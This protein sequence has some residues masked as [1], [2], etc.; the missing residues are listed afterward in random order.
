MPRITI[1]LDVPTDDLA[2]RLADMSVNFSPKKSSNDGKASSAGSATSATS[3]RSKA[4][5]SPFVDT[6][7]PDD[8]T[9]KPKKEE[10]EEPWE[11]E[12]WAILKGVGPGVY[13]VGSDEFT[14][15]RGVSRFTKYKK[16]PTYRAA[17]KAYDEA[18]RRGETC[19]YS[20]AWDAKTKNGMPANP[21]MPKSTA[22]GKSS[23]RKKSSSSKGAGQGGRGRPPWAHG[24]KRVFLER[25]LPEYIKIA[26][27]K[28][29]VS[30]LYAKITRM[31]LIKYT[32]DL[33]I[34][35]DS[36]EPLEDPDE[37]QL[38]EVSEYVDIDEAEQVRRDDFKREVHRRISAWY[39]VH[40]RRLPAATTGADDTFTSLLEEI[41]QPPRRGQVIHMYSKHH[42]AT[43][44]ASR[45][46]RLQKKYAATGDDKDD[47]GDNNDD[48]DDGEEGVGEGVEENSSDAGGADANGG[49]KP[50][51]RSKDVHLRMRAIRES[52]ATETEEVKREM[53]AL[54]DE[55]YDTAMEDYRS[56]FLQMPLT[57][58]EREWTSGHAYMFLQPIVDMVSTR[59]NCATSLFIAG[60]VPS[61]DGHVEVHSVHA[62]KKQGLIDELWPQHD[63][64]AYE[65]VSESMA[66]FARV[67]F[68]TEILRMAQK[69]SNHGGGAAPT[70]SSVS[71]DSAL[72]SD[73]P[74]GSTSFNAQQASVATRPSSLSTPQQSESTSG[75]A[76]PA[77]AASPDTALNLTA[78]AST[79]S[80]SD[81]AAEHG[82]S[83]PRTDSSACSG[84]APPTS[85]DSSLPVS[86][87]ATESSP[88]APSSSIPPYPSPLASHGNRTASDKA[89][90]T[91]SLGPDAQRVLDGT[92]RG[93]PDTTS[94]TAAG[95]VLPSNLPPESS[96]S[97]R[98]QAEKR[99]PTATP[100]D[101]IAR[102]VDGGSSMPPPLDLTASNVANAP[103]APRTT[104]L[105]IATVG[106]AATN[107]TTSSM[108]STTAADIHGAP[109][110]ATVTSTTAPLSCV[111]QPADAVA[112]SQSQADRGWPEL[113]DR[114]VMKFRSAALG[115]DWE[116][117]VTRFSMFEEALSF[118][119]GPGESLSL[120]TKHRPEEVRLWQK[121][122]RP[123]HNGKIINLDT[124]MTR[125]EDWWNALQPAERFNSEGE[126]MAPSASM[127][128]SALCIAGPNGLLSVLAALL[129]WGL[130]VKDDVE[131]Y[132]HQRWLN[133][134]VD[135]STV[136]FVS[137]AGNVA[138]ATSM[139]QAVSGSSKGRK[140]RTEAPAPEGKSKKRS[141]YVLFFRRAV[142][143]F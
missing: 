135:V 64:A 11:G 111:P 112:S 74:T 20:K 23:R 122:R 82:R 88:P 95:T 67:A 89:P 98:T 59:F 110:A 15:A 40:V 39:P 80:A 115:Q 31:F 16:Y 129:W 4:S 100:I 105:L 8:E 118:G 25:W 48:D 84:A 78:T 96:T 19:P 93:S 21:N 102:G 66:S 117:L 60:P 92:S 114:G 6:T 18:V 76:G 108:A 83:V 119:D 87:S 62:G 65:V 71:D 51:G 46:D 56:K 133:V 141:R 72:D 79:L 123:W 63:R 109:A 94:E 35:Q 1:T 61:K 68:A 52:W 90:S 43:K 85:L 42:W 130:A 12:T 30:K 131:D 3:A 134:T 34:D 97:P 47:D 103:P 116:T 137:H 14:E 22:G 69:K 45:Y 107:P 86:D 24:T 29:E 44:I 55:A 128:W 139:D 142:L 70:R 33:P 101:S 99:A 41:V 50:V 125:C 9:V 49:G 140:R 77:R 27:N 54:V 75:S 28:A 13:R 32:Y 26:G 17:R 2:D 91:K 124:F 106:D 81:N 138:R 10:E 113:F 7:V 57:D 58:E 136:L 127:D 104:T 120:G 126:V 143:V 36:T 38:E 53:K 121:S 73:A 5:S 132:T 37:A